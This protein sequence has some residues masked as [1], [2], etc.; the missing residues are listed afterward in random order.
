MIASIIAGMFFFLAAGS[1]ASYC[2]C[3]VDR[4]HCVSAVVS[5]VAS[6]ICLFSFIITPFIFLK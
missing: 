2:V 5:A 4:G 6:I 3:S 1:C